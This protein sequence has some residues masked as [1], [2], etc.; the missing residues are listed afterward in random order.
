M[1]EV[2]KSL[3]REQPVQQGRPNASC[4]ASERGKMARNTL[5]QNKDITGLEK[6]DEEGLFPDSGHTG[7]NTTLMPKH[8]AAILT[9]TEEGVLSHSSLRKKTFITE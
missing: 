2:T 7:I 8:Q 5:N 3:I 1:K 9:Q 4:L 6:G